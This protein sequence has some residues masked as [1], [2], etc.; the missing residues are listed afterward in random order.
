MFKCQNFVSGHEYFLKV[1][2]NGHELR[3]KPDFKSV[4]VWVIYMTHLQQLIYNDMYAKIDLTQN[5]VFN[6]N[7]KLR[8]K[9][10]DWDNQSRCLLIIKNFISAGWLEIVWKFNFNWNDASSWLKYSFRLLLPLF[11]CQQLVSSYLFEITND[12][13]C[14]RSF[15]QKNN[16]FYVC[17]LIKNQ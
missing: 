2:R 10:T 5:F 6:L 4:S 14:N 17:D 15:S 7:T 1:E 8:T 11:I 9:S 13:V 12:F 3:I 16:L